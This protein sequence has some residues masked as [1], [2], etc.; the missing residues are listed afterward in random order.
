MFQLNEG[1]GVFAL[2]EG[3]APTSTWTSKLP[4]PTRPESTSTCDLTWVAPIRAESPC[5]PRSFQTWATSSP[6]DQSSVLAPA[7]REV[8][9]PWR[10]DARAEARR[11]RIHGAL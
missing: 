7:G 6:S 1:S 9:R 5:P 10:V 2:R 11:L 3:G 4:G 8:V